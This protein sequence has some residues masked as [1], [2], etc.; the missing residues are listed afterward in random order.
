MKFA[1]IIIYIDHLQKHGSRKPVPSGRMEIVTEERTY[2]GIHAIPSLVMAAMESSGIRRHID[3]LCR[4]RI[5]KGCFLSPGMAV[6]AMVGTMVE[7][8]KRP[9]YCVSDYY[10]T[11]P[12]DKLFGNL[13]DNNSLSDTVLAERLD[14]IFE[15]DAEQI[16]L[17]C[18]GKLRDMYGFASDRLFMDATN[19]TMF[20]KKYVETQFN[21]DLK[22]IEKG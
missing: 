21:H 5:G 12:T 13:V 22:L 15:L 6:K 1:K 7:R 4:D 19:Y 9:L 11:A 10:S 16:L 8:G 14:D 20:G 2:E 3:E 18:Y 17:D